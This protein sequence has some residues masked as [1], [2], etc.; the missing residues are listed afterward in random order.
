[1]LAVNVGKIVKEKI[2]MARLQTFPRPNSGT[3]CD[4]PSTKCLAAG[5]VVAG[6]ADDIDLRRIKVMPMF[7]LS[8]LPGERAQLIPIVMIVRESAEF[9]E[10]PQTVA[11]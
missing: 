4:R 7:F 2:W 9:E 10:L 11:G 8:A 6:I 5:Y 1:M 3:D